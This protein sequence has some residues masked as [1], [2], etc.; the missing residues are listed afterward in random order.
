[1]AEKVCISPKG[2]FDANGR[3]RHAIRLNFTLN[4]EEQLVEAVRRL[5]KATQHLL[6]EDE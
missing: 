1:M 4:N 5:I 3:N 2:V 6:Q